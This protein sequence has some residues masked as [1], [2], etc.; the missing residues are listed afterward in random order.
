MRGQRESVASAHQIEEEGRIGLVLVLLQVAD[1]VCLRANEL[2]PEL[3]AEVKVIV[4]KVR[5]DHLAR[6]PR[7]SERVND[8]TMR[9]ATVQV[10]TRSRRPTCKRVKRCRARPASAASQVFEDARRG[11]FFFT[12]KIKKEFLLNFETEG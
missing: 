8:C 1:A 9:T 6:A 5:G 12:E 11:D 3:L 4:A 10:S 7:G 2:E